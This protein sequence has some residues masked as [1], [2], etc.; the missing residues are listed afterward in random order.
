MQINNAGVA[1]NVVDPEAQRTVKYDMNEVRILILTLLLLLLLL[2]VLISSYIFFFHHIALQIQGKGKMIYHSQF[3]FQLAGPKAKKSEIFKQSL[4]GSET[5][6]K[7]NY[8][9]VKL[10]T[11][12]LIPLLQLSDN[13]KIVNVSAS[14]GQLQV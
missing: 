11:E 8:Y 1:G 5:C 2:S 4:E 7:T 13:P 14:L 3:C 6:L 9:G 10:L 12:E